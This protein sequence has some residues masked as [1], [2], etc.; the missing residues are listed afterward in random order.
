MDKPYN[1]NSVD[2]EVSLG[3]PLEAVTESLT[4]DFNSAPIRCVVCGNTPRYK[5]I[6]KRASLDTPLLQSQGYLCEH[7]MNQRAVSPS[8]YSL[9]DLTKK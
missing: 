1:P 9:R 2:F 6:P 8:D 5:L 7:C 4:Y 3:Q